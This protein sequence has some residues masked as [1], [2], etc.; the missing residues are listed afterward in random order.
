MSADEYYRMVAQPQ[1]TA[2]GPVAS[3]DDALDRVHETHR[4][5][6]RVG[7]CINCDSLVCGEFMGVTPRG[8]APCVADASPDAALSWLRS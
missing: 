4:I 7:W 2:A 6:Y 5:A 8:E 1:A 3:Y